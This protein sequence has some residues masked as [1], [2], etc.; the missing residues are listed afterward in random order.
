MDTR[1]APWLLLALALAASA[2]ATA[3]ERGANLVRNPSF[4][5]DSV[6]EAVSG[7]FAYDA[8]VAHSG[9]RSVRVSGDDLE[10]SSG[11][12]QVIEL[13]PPVAH[14][15]RI[16]GW[17]RAEGAEV[18]Q[19]YDIYLDLTYDDGTPLWGQTARFEPGT[20]DW[21]SAQFDFDP[22]KPV[23]RI[24]VFVL[25]RK[26]KGTVWFDDIQV[27]LR[28]FAFTGLDLTPG[29]FGGTSLGI[30]ANTT[31]P[32]RWRMAI[33]GP[34]GTRAE[35]R[36][37]GSR[38]RAIWAGSPRAAAGTYRVSLTA[39][40][41]LRGEAIRETRELELGAGGPDGPYRLWI[42]DSMVRVLPDAFPPSRPGRPVASLSLAGNEYES[43]QLAFLAAPGARVEGLSLET[44][45]L[46]GRSGARI[47]AS[48]IEWH[49][50]G[51]VHAERLLGHP[52]YPEASPGWWPDP[53]LEVGRFSL[54]PGR[55]QAIWVTVH[56]PAGTPAG[57]YEGTLAIVQPGRPDTEVE[58][59]AHVYGFDLPVQ[60]HL[61]TAFA[62]MDGYLEKVYGKPLSAELRQRYGDFVLEH[63]LNPD[64]ISRTDPPAIEDLLR[65]DSRG[66]NAFNV[67]NM[68]EPRGENAWV[69]WSPLEVYT[70]EFK[71]Y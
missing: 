38:F 48:E 68:V 31:M 24:E 27:C 39:R 26:A 40:D 49:Q 43:F 1:I 29:L 69:W 60:G 50:V 34:G 36:G 5:D 12:W 45:D 21:Q 20:H 4:E 6:W 57:D 62:L 47:A 58:V 22:S 52:A 54:E 30:T 18:G 55:T 37:E 32:A 25:F 61:K 7:G 64:D 63:R 3:Q 67:L 9:K 71:Q 44:S 66:L 23:R 41:G 51:F 70:P 16:S 28:P 8:G 53:L 2:S 10:A 19:D 59:R 56:A 46:V 17:S 11:L 65:Y 35:Q 14:P 13:D 33:S 15:F 42:E